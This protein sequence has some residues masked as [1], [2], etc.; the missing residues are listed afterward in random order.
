S[1]HG[2][3]KTLHE[4][5]VISRD[6]LYLLLKDTV[7]G[8]EPT[9]IV[10]FHQDAVSMAQLMYLSVEYL[11]RYNNFFGNESLF[12]NVQASITIPS[13]ISQQF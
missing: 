2:L 11:T 1:L 12:H 7:L 9:N 5:H 10:L 4:G 8:P 3:A 13:G 6:E